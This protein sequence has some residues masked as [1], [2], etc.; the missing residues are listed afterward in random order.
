L[1]N[2]KKENIHFDVMHIKAFPFNADVEGFFLEHD[3]VFVVEQNRDGQFRSL[4]INELELMPQKLLSVLH[5]DGM[6]IP[7]N[8]IYNQIK[9][10][11][12]ELAAVSQ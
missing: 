3:Q 6:P 7:A 12:P 4:L 5:F 2:L 1:E 9:K 10:Q 8:T 11:L